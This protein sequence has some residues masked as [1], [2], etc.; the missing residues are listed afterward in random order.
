VQILVL[1]DS[2]FMRGLLRKELMA[3]G[4]KENQINDVSTGADA[5]LKINSQTFD[6]CLL[7]IVMP[8]IDGIAVLKELKKVQPKAKVVMCSSHSSTDTIQ[9]L[10][11]MG[12]DDF[13]IKPFDVGVFKEAIL[14]NLPEGAI[15]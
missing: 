13:L 10:M 7:D 12:I 4:I 2:T 3:L 8:G 9:E 15:G 11:D 5:L 1:D 14:R 6:L